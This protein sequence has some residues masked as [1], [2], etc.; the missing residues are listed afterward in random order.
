MT[1][2]A[3]IYCLREDDIS[4]TSLSRKS[5]EDLNGGWHVEVL[6]GPEG[7][8]SLFKGTCSWNGFVASCCDDVRECTI[9]FFTG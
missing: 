2:L 1:D 3:A 4:G 6:V 7:K 5:A 8:L 9:F